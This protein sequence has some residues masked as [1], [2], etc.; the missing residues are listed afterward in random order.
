MALTKERIREI[1]DKRVQKMAQKGYFQ[2]GTDISPQHEAEL[3][4]YGKKQGITSVGEMIAALLIDFNENGAG[5]ATQE[6]VE[7]AFSRD[8]E[9]AKKTG[10]FLTDDQFNAIR[11]MHQKINPH[12]R[13][14]LSHGLA[15]LIEGSKKLNILEEIS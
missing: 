2:R 6:D 1:S 8:R 15:I 11:S 3:R 10:F 9:N 4:A 12:A 14:S 5:M 13:K 7:K